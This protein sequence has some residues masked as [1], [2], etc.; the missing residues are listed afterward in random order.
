MGSRHFKSSEKDLLLLNFD[1]QQV[2]A[3]LEGRLMNE[4]AVLCCLS[5]TLCADC[6][7][8]YP[9]ISDANL[10]EM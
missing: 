3:R 6:V 10:F 8:R 7:A 2:G 9:Y 5:A 4:R 1:N